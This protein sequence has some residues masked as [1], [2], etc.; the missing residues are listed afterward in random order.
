MTKNEKNPAKQIK[1]G[2]LLF[3]HN[4]LLD[5]NVTQTS[6]HQNLSPPQESPA[7]SE[8][9]NEFFKTWSEIHAKLCCPKITKLHN[10]YPIIDTNM[11]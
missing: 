6:P 7:D 10:T 2:L 9:H 5:I 4:P 1:Y 8:A 11:T 3:V